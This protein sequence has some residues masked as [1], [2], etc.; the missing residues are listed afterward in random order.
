[1]F[2]RKKR[3]SSLSGT[4][5]N[6]RKPSKSVT[7]DI[8][9]VKYVTLEDPLMI[10]STEFENITPKMLKNASAVFGSVNASACV[11]SEK[12]RSTASQSISLVFNP[13]APNSEETGVTIE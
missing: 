12:T 9:S 3:S 2:S 4:A 5:E 6:Y 1:M 11:Q 8:F 10:P 7:A 13:A